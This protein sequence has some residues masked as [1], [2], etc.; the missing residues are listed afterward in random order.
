MSVSVRV[1]GLGEMAKALVT[2][3]WTPA[4]VKAFRA[5]YMEFRKHVI[6]NSKELGQVKLG[7]V[8]M[9]G[10]QKRFLDAVFDALSKDIHDIKILKSRQV[11]ITTETRVLSLF[12]LGMHPG[13]K[14]SLV[15]DTNPHRDESRN[16]FITMM[17]DLPPEL[18]FPKLVKDGRDLMSLSNGSTFVFL[19][20][21]VRQSKASGT[22]GRSSGL[23]FV[24]ASEICSWSNQEGVVSFKNSLSK[25]YKNRLYIWE[26]TARGFNQWWQMWLDAKA[27]DLRQVTCFIGWWSKE[28]QRIAKGTKLFERY[29]SAPPTEEEVAKIEEVKERYG[30]A[31]DAEQLAWYRSMANPRMGAAAGQEEGET[32]VDEEFAIQEQPFTESDCF[33]QSGSTF[34][35]GERLTAITK[36][37]VSEKYQMY[38]FSQGSEFLDSDWQPAFRKKDAQ[39]KV[40]EEPDADGIYVVACDPAFGHDEAN[41]HSAVQVLRCYADCIEQVAEYAYSGIQTEPFAW[42]IGA[43]AGWYKNSYVILE[44]NGPGEA[45]WL[46]FKELKKLVLS[47]HLR[48]KASEKGLRDIFTNVRD[49]MYSRADST[50]TTSGTMHWKTQGS[51]KV[52][53]MERLRD[54]VSNGGLVIR[55]L[56]TV[57]EMKSVV[58]NGDIIGAENRNRDD[59][60]F[61]LAMGIRAWGDAI[62]RRMSVA[63]QTKEV[64]AAKRRLTVK[65]QIVMFNKHKLDT[66]FKGKQTE[67]IRMANAKNRA[68]WRNR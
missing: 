8:P 23:N 7:D 33:I 26:S 49:F 21:G 64:E 56:D 45:V 34:F 9:Y 39:L 58:R 10:S 57:E 52:G 48:S 63:G 24:H 1:M 36:A 44:I 2:T 47:G 66:F 20:A 3:A 15:F 60:T 11:G 37:N 19:S 29:G 43:L 14:G 25:D 40:W 13:L 6:I 5:A 32:T 22:L 46:A 61:C 65:D 68:R 38:Y 30:V 17:R 54:F 18:N 28:N 59:R 51:N 42:V 41:N 31:I 4:K 62:R 55:S 12:W 35:S 67:R 53:L 27:D 50:N 16:E